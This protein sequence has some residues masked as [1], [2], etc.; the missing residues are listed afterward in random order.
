MT[1][2]KNQP[3][4]NSLYYGD[5]LEVMQEWP[6]AFVD[7][8]YLDPPFNS[9]VN[10]NIIFGN[11]RKKNTAQLIAFEDTWSWN[12]EAHERTHNIINAAGHPAYKAIQGL[13]MILGES[14]MMAYL[15]YM[16]ER[17][18]EIKRVLKPAGS[19]YLHCDPTASH[20]LK[21]MMDR[22]FG[23]QNFLN[24]IVWHY[25]K[26]TN[27]AKMYQQNH[28]LILCYAMNKGTH[29]FNKQFND[30]ESEHYKKGYHTNVVE[31]G[32]SQLIVYDKKKAEHKIKSDQYDRVIYR[33]G[34]QQ[35]VLADVWE[36]PII[37]PMAKERTGYPTQKPIALLERIISASSH[38][39]DVVLDP[40]S[41]CGTTIQAAINLQRKWIGIDISP[42]A[43]DLIKNERIKRPDTP[44]SGIP[45]DMEGAA[46][47]A[48][49]KPFDFEKWAIS[50]I[51]GLAPNQ[52]QVGDRG[53]D[54]RGHMAFN[55]KKML[56]LA[57]VKGGKFNISAV[58]DFLGVIHREKA[59]M[60]IFITLDRI[61]Q[62]KDLK[63][64]IAQAG[65][66]TIGATRY[67][68]LQL[69]SIQDYFENKDPKLPPMKD[70]FT[71]KEIQR[72]IF[73]DVR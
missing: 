26:W 16:A 49:K 57:Q 25:G 9:K 37:N 61:T 14:G 71:G 68:C 38:K 39:D 54:G 19:V 32:I 52:K 7:L 70:P 27:V 63:T 50:R 23:H 41:G 13:L 2:K 48:K 59:A 10:Y 12:D 18:V 40:F 35:V 53:I 21:I 46:I 47:M 51:P 20:Y 43:I 3:Q 28:D 62:S 69:W 42:I 73:D 56:V 30:K 58:R 45:T 29:V 65:K 4:L 34:Q 72:S 5:C 64:E 11:R 66:E 36:I 15:S 22:I 31:N 55:N 24:E 17:L 60:G 1:H 6:N 8:C 67:P 44:V 33:E